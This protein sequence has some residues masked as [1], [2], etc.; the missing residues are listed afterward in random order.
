MSLK[1]DSTS[2]GW[3][4]KSVVLRDVPC[5]WVCS[6]HGQAKVNKGNEDDDEDSEEEGDMVR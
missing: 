5:L 1:L 6:Y 3:M 2:T 4:A